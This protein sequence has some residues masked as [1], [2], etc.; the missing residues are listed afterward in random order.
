M[1]TF[2]IGIR[3]GNS[4]VARNGNMTTFPIQTTT[5]TPIVN[6]NIGGQSPVGQ[7]TIP[8]TISAR[9]NQ[10]SPMELSPYR[11]IVRPQ[12]NIDILKS[13][14]K[15]GIYS[16]GFKAEMDET[17]ALNS[18]TSMI[19]KKNLDGVCLNII[20]ELSLEFKV[21]GAIVMSCTS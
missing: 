21:F 2:G 1:S 15:E 20:N 14:D 16:I 10:P 19:E 8:T 3:N 12:Q 11:T 17:T 9:S 13:L 6:T 7:V 18:A 5:E 4:V